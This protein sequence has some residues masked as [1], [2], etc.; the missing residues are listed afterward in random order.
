MRAQISQGKAHR[1][2]RFFARDGMLQHNFTF[3]KEGSLAKPSPFSSLI[4]I[5]IRKRNH[6]PNHLSDPHF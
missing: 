5:K 2:E 3:L 6:E 1:P 4:I